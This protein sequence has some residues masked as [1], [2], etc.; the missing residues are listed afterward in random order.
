M[1]PQKLCDFINLHLIDQDCTNYS[2]YGHVVGACAA[3]L[4]AVNVGLTTP[5]SK[6]H[7]K[8]VQSLIELHSFHVFCCCVGAI[9]GM[10]GTMDVDCTVSSLEHIAFCVDLKFSSYIVVL[11]AG[12]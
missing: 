10:I 7:Q 4:P 9:G 12:V 8:I 11:P 3:D 2:Q 5:G 6:P 1:F